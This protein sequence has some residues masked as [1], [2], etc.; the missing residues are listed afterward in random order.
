MFQ[1]ANMWSEQVQQI[2]MWWWCFSAI[3]Y[4]SEYF[5]QKLLKYFGWFRKCSSIITADNNNFFLNSLWS[6]SVAGRYLFNSMIS[7][8]GFDLMIQVRKGRCNSETSPNDSKHIESIPF[9]WCS[10]WSGTSDS[11]NKTS[12]C[13]QQSSTPFAIRSHL[14]YCVEVLTRSRWIYSYRFQNPENQLER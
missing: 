4:L 10:A 14:L 6:S 11:V 3:I 8:W 12:R 9:K 1:S 7:I 5:H 13:R 2:M